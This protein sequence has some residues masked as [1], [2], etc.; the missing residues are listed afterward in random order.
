MKQDQ[1]VINALAKLPHHEHAV[2]V[3]IL[4]FFLDHDDDGRRKAKIA[5]SQKV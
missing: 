1:K 3:Q 4:D 5:F 2:P